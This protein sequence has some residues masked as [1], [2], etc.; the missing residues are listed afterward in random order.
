MGNYRLVHRTSTELRPNQKHALQVISRKKLDRIILMQT[1]LSMAA[2]PS[3]DSAAVGLPL[4]VMA[5][6]SSRQVTLT[7]GEHDYEIAGVT[8]RACLYNG[9]L[10]GPIIR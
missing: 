8:Y 2:I 5:E 6:D 3:A 9:M 7:L 10:G 4:Q 1:L